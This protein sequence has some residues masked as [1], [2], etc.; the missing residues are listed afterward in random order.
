[1]E[2]GQGDMA[3]SSCIGSNIFDITICLPVPWLL[4]CAIHQEPY[5]KQYAIGKLR[6]IYTRLSSW[7]GW[8]ILNQMIC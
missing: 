1:M 5:I 7:E 8:L 4:Y 3:V 2:Q 6:L